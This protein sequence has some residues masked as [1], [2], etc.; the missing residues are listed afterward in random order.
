M[1]EL[2]MLRPLTSA[3][4]YL[5][6]ADE[7]LEKGDVVQASEKYYKAVEEAIKILA[8]ENK[9]STLNEAKA[10]GSWD[11][12]TL[13]KAINELA[14][15]YGERIIIDW[16]ASVSLVTT[17]LSPNSIK[18]VV[19]YVRDIVNLASANKRLD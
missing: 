4:A 10:K 11:L 3:E 19:K 5:Q 7:L 8:V 9:I 12:E 16:S 18:D 13:N 14:K 2:Y 17:N 15:I 1:K 6:E